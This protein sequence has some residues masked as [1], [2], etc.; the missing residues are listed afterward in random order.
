MLASLFHIGFDNERVFGAVT[1]RKGGVSKPPFDT[2]NMGFQTGDNAQSVKQ[3]YH[4][5]LSQ[6]PPT[7]S[8]FVL[9]Y[10]SHSTVVKKVTQADAGKGLASFESGVQAD[11]LYTTEKKLPI[12]IFHADCV[13]I[14]LVH[15]T[16]PLI[17]ILH[18]G[19]PGTLNSISLKAVQFICNEENVLPS[20][21]DAYLGPS[22]DFA[23][24]P[25]TIERMNEILSINANFA[26]AIKLISGQLFLDVPLMNYMQL[27]DAGLLPTSIRVSSID[28]FSNAK[29]YFS[30]SRESQTGRHLSFIYLK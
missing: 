27:I 9:T 30:A 4:I 6:L 19:T 22:L 13:P 28:T 8:P 20:E 29:E 18:A 23:H 15:Q 3:N 2:L 12:G 17:A 25:I 10:Q 1:K 14:F 21:L 16:Q 5:V 11:A 7:L 24:H 26:P